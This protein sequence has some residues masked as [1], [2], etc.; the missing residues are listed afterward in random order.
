[1]FICI[2]MFIPEGLLR[3]LQVQTKPPP[4]QAGSQGTCKPGFNPIFIIYQAFSAC[5]VSNV[6]PG[7]RG[8][9]KPAF[10]PIIMIYQAFS[11]CIVLN[12][13]PGFGGTRKP[14]FHPIFMIY[15][16]FFACT[17][18]PPSC[19]GTWWLPQAPL[20]PLEVDCIVAER[21]IGRCLKTGLSC[22][23]KVLSPFFGGK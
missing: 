1:M 2:C 15:Q 23:V 4:G 9:C 11:A 22:G 10:N 21:C 7:F 19:R 20:L 13:H 16:A 17:V 12:V 3:W 18:R 6:H 8:T 14:G 5:I